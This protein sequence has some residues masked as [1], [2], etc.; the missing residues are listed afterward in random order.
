MQEACD[1]LVQGLLPARASPAARLRAR[2]LAMACVVAV[3][4]AVTTW[5]EGGMKEDLARILG[6]AAS[7]LRRGFEA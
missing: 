4:A 3:D 7:H 5:I 6:E 1:L 2:L